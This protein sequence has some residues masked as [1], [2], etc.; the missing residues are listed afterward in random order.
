MILSD[1][2]MFDSFFEV[3]SE[4]IRICESLLIFCL[5]EINKKCLADVVLF[6]GAKLILEISFGIAILSIVKQL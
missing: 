4:I 2:M 1:F 5:S 3:F 6:D